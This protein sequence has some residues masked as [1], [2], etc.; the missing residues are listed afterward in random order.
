M[1]EEEGGMDGQ[2]DGRR[3]S[4]SEVQMGQIFA[5]PKPFF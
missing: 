3:G 2:T 5:P 4:I 1:R